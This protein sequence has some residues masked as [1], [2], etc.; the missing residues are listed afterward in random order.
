LILLSFFFR[1]NITKPDNWPDSSDLGWKRIVR[2]PVGE[3]VP[4]SRHPLSD[5]GRAH[6]VPERL[7]VM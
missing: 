3:K 2:V 4:L 6:L 5:I 7:A 1:P